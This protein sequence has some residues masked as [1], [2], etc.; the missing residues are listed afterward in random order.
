M[1]SFVSDKCFG[2]T[3]TCL[4]MLWGNTTSGRQAGSL[5]CH[6]SLC[7]WTS[8]SYYGSSIKNSCWFASDHWTGFCAVAF[9]CGNSLSS[10][11]L[12]LTWW[13][14]QQVSP[15][16]G[17]FSIRLTFQIHQSSLW[18]PWDHWNSQ[19]AVEIWS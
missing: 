9:Q 5:T 19:K 17:T 8:M 2:L 12:D 13:K 1:I 4:F 7:L 3:D 11:M 18:V 16:A 10:W 14:R 15:K 6:H